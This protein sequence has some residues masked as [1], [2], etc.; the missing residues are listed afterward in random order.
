MYDNEITYTC[1]IKIDGVSIHPYITDFDISLSEGDYVNSI[2]I[3]FN[4]EA[5]SL[6]T[7]CDPNVNF[8]QERVSAT[9]NSH[10]FKF[11]V[12]R[13]S[14]SLNS[15]EKT[16]A[17]WGRSKAA[18]LDLPYSAPISD[19]ADSTNLW[20]AGDVLASVIV[21][22]LLTGTGITCSFNIDDFIVYGAN[23]SIENQTPIQ[24]INKVAAVPGGRVRSD[25]NGNLILDYKVFSTSFVADTT[26]E[27]TDIDEIIQLGEDVSHPPGYNYVRITGYED[28]TSPAGKNIRIELDEAEGSCASAG[29]AFMVRVYASPITL[30]YTFDTTIGTFYHIGDY[31]STHEETVHF[32]NGKGN[33]QYPIY[34]VTSASWHGD[35]LGNITWGQGYTGLVADVE[36]YG[37]L[38]YVY[39]AKYT[40][41]EVV[42]VEI[43]DAILFAE[44][45]V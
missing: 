13:R 32:S 4:T 17:V 12:E 18:T 2:T 43:G 9:I 6:F 5:W 41:Y 42:V 29:N 35:S 19:T 34:S 27:F 22:D 8:G 24:I 3:N 7:M 23:F 15:K 39:S 40:L 37:V 36:G 25:Q 33:T 31:Y 38:N 10:E 28:I 20:Q 30:E 26:A 16:F 14:T 21:D 11:L 44:E 1:S 45:D